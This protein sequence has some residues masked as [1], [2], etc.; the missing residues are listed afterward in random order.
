MGIIFDTKNYDKVEP[1]VV[2]AIDSFFDSML[3][4]Q[5]SAATKLKEVKLCS[6]MKYAD[7]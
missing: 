6:I 1:E 2:A 3:L 5:N 4:D 7:M